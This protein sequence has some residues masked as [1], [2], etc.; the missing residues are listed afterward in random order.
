MKIACSGYTHV[1]KITHHPGKGS[2]MELTTATREMIAKKA[3]ERFIT[4]GKK[5]GFALEDWIIAEKE[6]VGSGIQV[7]KPR[8][9]H[10]AQEIVS[11]KKTGRNHITGIKVTSYA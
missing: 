4:R 10:Q 7:S 5:D 3:Y 8:E 2:S 1:K 9:K 11:A 6:V